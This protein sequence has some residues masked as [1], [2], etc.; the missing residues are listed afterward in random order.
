MGRH[1]GAGDASGE[2]ER[3]LIDHVHIRVADLGESVR[4][5]DAVLATVGIEKTS[6]HGPTVE[7][8][9]FIVSAGD[10]PLS[11]DVHV[12]FEAASRD[13]VEAFHR[14][15]VEAG[16]RGNG[17]PGLRERYAPGY[18]SAFLLDP[19]GHNVEAVVYS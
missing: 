13:Q 11:R 12:A 18:Y 9:D 6:E 15:G 5:Y 3:R 19:D 2:R 8:G 7:Y 14:A 1:A 16:Y 17:E 4:F 10:G